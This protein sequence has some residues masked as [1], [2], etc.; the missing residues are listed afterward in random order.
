MAVWPFKLWCRFCFCP[1]PQIRAE[2]RKNNPKRNTLTFC[3]KL[4]YAPNPVRFQK[5]SGLCGCERAL[6]H[7]S[8]RPWQMMGEQLEASVPNALCP[9]AET[10][11]SP[12]AKYVEQRFY[13]SMSLRSETGIRGGNVPNARTGELA[14]KVAPRNLGL[15]SEDFQENLC[16][17]GSVSGPL[18]IQNSPSLIFGD[19]TP[20][21]NQSIAIYRAM[22]L[23]MS[24]KMPIILEGEFN[25][26]YLVEVDH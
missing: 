21:S 2:S 5:T 18:K 24:L 16:R 25:A 22:P 14:P 7:R 10:P 23:E 3:L 1:S 13:W 11:A 20:V 19:L 9:V 15:L 26:A 4:S 6:C 17:K 12:I 8:K